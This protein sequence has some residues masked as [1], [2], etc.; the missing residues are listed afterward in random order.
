MVN[1]AAMLAIVR[2]TLKNTNSRVS[3]SI[4]L[5]HT[6]FRQYMN[7]AGRWVVVAASFVK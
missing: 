5:R 4:S 7:F 3:F 6:G 2:K 1:Y